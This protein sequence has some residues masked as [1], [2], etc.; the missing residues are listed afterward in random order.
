MDVLVAV[1]VVWDRRSVISLLMKHV[2]ADMER[3]RQEK[4][5]GRALMQATR[6]QLSTP[7]SDLRLK[8]VWRGSTLKIVMLQSAGLMAGRRLKTL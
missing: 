2:H 6:R 3:W 4:T 5:G 1:I 7:G 8:N